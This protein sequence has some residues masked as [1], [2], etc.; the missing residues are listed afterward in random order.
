MDASKRGPLVLALVAAAALALPLIGA[1]AQPLAKPA[2][3]PA[4]ALDSRSPA[5][6][7][8]TAIVA[9][10]CFWGVQGVFE[11]VR[12]VTKAVSGYAGGRAA[13]PSYE[14]V[15]TGATGH[16]ESVKITFD[17]RQITYGEILQIF[18]S[19]A[20]D[21]TQLNRQAPDEGTQYRSEIFYVTPEQQKIAKAY[22]AQLQAAHAFPRPIVTRVDPDTGFYAAEAYHQDYLT[23]HPAQP[24]IAINDLPKVAALKRLFPAAYRVD[25]VLVRPKA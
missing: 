10:G 18:F 12:G 23:L 14:D 25:P 16:A 3:L 20:T 13:N 5:P 17:P 22:I 7:L 21:P 4:P 24:Y 1:N 2:H 15:S 6:G 19:V 8:E 9:G 11:H